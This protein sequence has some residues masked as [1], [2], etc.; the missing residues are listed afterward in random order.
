M[1]TG[2]I[3]DVGEVREV[4]RQAGGL[5]L[6]VRTA[7]PLAEIQ[8]GDSVAVNGVCLTV[9]ALHDNAF[10]A[11]VSPETFSCTALGALAPHTAV[12]LERALR[13]GDRLGG[14][15]VYGHVDGVARLVSRRADGNAIRMAF[16]MKSSVNRYLVPKGSVAIDGIS[17][18]VNTVSDDG[19]AIAV[20]P[21][22]LE[23]TTLRQRKVGEL[24]N[25]EVD[26]FAKFAERLLAGSDETA[27]VREDSPARSPLTEAF[28]AGHGFL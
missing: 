9:T 19:F 3:E 15:L 18:T 27:P 1:F 23:K 5:V 21:H 8:L 12:N 7:L 10:E 28:L 11:D 22:T 17:L 4:R 26:I 2:L 25:I 13:L 24:V 6:T 14:H 20:I 16:Q